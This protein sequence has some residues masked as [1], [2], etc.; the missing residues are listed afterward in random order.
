M[1][2]SG[3][4]LSSDES[5]KGFSA[6]QAGFTLIELMMVM[7]IIILVSGGSLT[8][9]LNFNKTQST[10]NDARKLVAEIY[11]VRTLAATLQYPS[12]CTSLTGYNLKSSLVNSD[13]S[14]M[15]VS[16]L[17]SPAN[18]EIPD[19]QIL[20][21]SV[22]VS[23]L[24]LIFKPGTGYLSTGSDIVITIANKSDPTVTK[25]VTIGAYGVVNG[26]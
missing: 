6:R 15:S 10:I 12:D 7:V 21:N 22:F 13:L 26:N 8:A 18:V 2:G 20:T 19:T 25:A 16:V 17:C 4:N 24:N 3:H 11:R 14:G 1:Y 9:Y 23:P 5:V